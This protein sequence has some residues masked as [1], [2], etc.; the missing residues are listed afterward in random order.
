MYVWLLCLVP[1]ILTFAVSDP[2]DCE[3]CKDPALFSRMP[4]F[5]ISEYQELD[6]SRYSFPVGYDR[7]QVVEGQ[8]TYLDYYANDGVKYP[9]GMQ[10]VA[11]YKNAVKSIGGETVYEFEDGGTQYITLKVVKNNVEVWVYVEGPSN[12]M[13]KVFLVEKQA[14]KQD[15][16]ASADSLLGAIRQTG[17]VAVYGIYFDTAKS[18]LKPDSEP[19]LKEIAKL[20]KTDPK[21]KLY[22]VGHTDNQGAFDYNLT[23]SNAR[24]NAV[25]QALTGK[26]G[27]AVSRLTPFGAGPTSPVASN[28]SEEGR[29]LNRRV[30]LVAQ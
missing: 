23:L 30:E 29:A 16:V 21:L 9:S 19:T 20:L 15:I 28:S 24:A 13:Y 12:G 26:Y 3:G 8:Y 10:I 18:D 1:S 2:N 22:V 4:G 11:N 14:M 5:Y 27:V 6:F 25:I 17:R 7:V